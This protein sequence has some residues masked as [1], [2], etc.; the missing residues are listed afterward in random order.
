[1]DICGNTFTTGSAPGDRFVKLVEMMKS[2]KGVQ[3]ES[4]T[5]SAC[6]HF[7]NT[8]FLILTHLLFFLHCKKKNRKKN[9][10]Q[11]KK[12]YDT[13]IVLRS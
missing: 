12:H 2:M 5:Y 11:S 1:M 8:F 13:N 7:H 9:P 3:T 6:L 10:E 4:E